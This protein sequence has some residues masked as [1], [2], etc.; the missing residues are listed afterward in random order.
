[1]EGRDHNNNINYLKFCSPGKT[2]FGEAKQLLNFPES[3]TFVR[4]RHRFVYTTC[5]SWFGCHR[6]PARDPGSC[7]CL[8]SVSSQ[9]ILL[10]HNENSQGPLQ[11]SQ[12][13]LTE[14]MMCPYCSGN[15]GG[16]GSIQ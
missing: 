15:C 8:Q 16:N 11:G 6:F 14:I 3:R 5:S 7:W 9:E 4:I 2:M 10:A 1:M 12:K 13:K